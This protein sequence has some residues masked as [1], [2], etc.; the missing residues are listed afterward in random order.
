MYDLIILAGAPASG[1]NS[2][3]ELLKK[4][5]SSPNV[6]LGKLRGFH[7]DEDWKSRD[8]EELALSS[9]NLIFIVK[10]YLRHGYKNIIVHDMWT[11]L[12][13]QMV[14]EFPN[15]II[16]TFV[17]NNEELEKRIILRNAGFKDVPK[18]QKWNDAHKARELLPNEHRI[19][20]T[21]QSLKQT[22]KEVVELLES[23]R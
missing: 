8:P 12:L 22:F 16:F 3:A 1:K 15:S 11:E 18:G 20:N 19:D 13:K 10:N 23:G 6:D 4:K 7:F 14:K 2:I 5:F 21:N 9:E 17:P